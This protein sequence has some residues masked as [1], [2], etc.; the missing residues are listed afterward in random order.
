MFEDK[1][2]KSIILL[3]HCII[4]QNAKSD[5]TASYGGTITELVDLINSI[6]IGIVQMPCPELHC[7]GLDR[8][9]VNGSMRPVIE[10]NSRI[11]NV[12][13]QESSLKIIRGLIQ[14][15]VYQIEE[16][17]K[18]GFE[19]KGVIG[20]N[21]SPSCGVESTSMDNEEIAGQGVFIKELQKQFEKKEFQIP[22]V[23]IKVFE[24]E[25]AL[26]IVKN[27]IGLG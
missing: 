26:T 2:S 1:R 5:G 21:R 6:D 24:P 13:K 3:A 16:Y 11:R 20:I 7:L 14:S 9:D 23:G 27:V 25:N 15:V 22:I 8:G 12:I 17:L 19:I 4:N 18:N 10:E